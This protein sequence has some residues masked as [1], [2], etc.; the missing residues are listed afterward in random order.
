[1]QQRW[2][3]STLEVA[4]KDDR[5]MHLMRSLFSFLAK[6]NV[7]LWVEHIP[8][9]QNEAADALSHNNHLSFLSQVPSTRRAPSQIPPGLLQVLVQ[10]QPDW[11]SRSWTTL[12]EILYE[13]TS[14]L[15]TESLQVQPESFSGLLQAGNYKAVPASETVLCHFVSYLA[16]QKLKHRTIKV[17]LSVVHFHIPEGA[18]DPFHPSLD[19][20]QYML[21]EIKRVEAYSRS[22][23]RERLPISPDILRN[24]KAVWEASGSGSDI[25]MLWATYFLV[26]F[27]FLRIGEMTVPSDTIY[28]PSAHFVSKTS[29]WIVLQ[30]PR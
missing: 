20:L 18:G 2:Q 1:M 19:C 25:V 14:R 12:L 28:D 5:A 17:Y 15:H 9:E 4:I 11:T 24:V 10:K 8:G 6:Y 23:G 7:M 22:A 16:E 13:G 30:L 26:F 29:R 21:C 27:G 3:L